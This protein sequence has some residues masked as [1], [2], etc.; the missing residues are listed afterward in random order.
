M[1]NM[2]RPGGRKPLGRTDLEL[3]S[4]G[5]GEEFSPLHIAQPCRELSHPI[6]GQQGHP[7]R[8]FSQNGVSRASVREPRLG[9]PSLG[10]D[11]PTQ[12]GA[13]S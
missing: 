8:I 7:A 5:P 3:R 11:S 10:P 9:A 4:W 1:Q 13:P 6:W 12:E 2:D